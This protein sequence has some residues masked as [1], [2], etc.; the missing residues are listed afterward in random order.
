MFPCRNTARQVTD[1]KGDFRAEDGL[2]EHAALSI[3]R[4]GSSHERTI[5]MTKTSLSALAVLV[6][7]SGLAAPALAD[8]LVSQSSDNEHFNETIV[9]SQLRA[10]GVEAS[11]LEYFNGRIRATVQDEDGRYSFAYFELGTLEQ[12]GPSGQARGNTRVLSERELGPD[13]RTLNAV[14]LSLVNDDADDE[15]N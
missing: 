12:V 4:K 2:W 15:D 1:F 7:V 13:A 6:A 9:L 8:S 5:E 3:W 10:Q 11:D 14:P